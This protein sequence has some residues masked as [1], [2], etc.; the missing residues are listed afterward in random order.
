MGECSVSGSIHTISLGTMLPGSYAHL[1]YTNYSYHRSTAAVKRE[2]FFLS[3]N[4]ANIPFVFLRTRRYG[5]VERN[6]G[7]RILELYGLQEAKSNDILRWG[8]SYCEA[9]LR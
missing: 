7:T 6:L 4:P 2:I 8:T 1:W 3:P 5:A 9:V